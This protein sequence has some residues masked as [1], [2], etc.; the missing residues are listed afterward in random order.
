MYFWDMFDISYFTLGP[1]QT[2][3]VASLTPVTNTFSPL[4]PLIAKFPPHHPVL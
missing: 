1:S 4:L 3:T 2:L